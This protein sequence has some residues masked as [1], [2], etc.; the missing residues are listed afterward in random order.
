MIFSFVCK[1]VYYLLK[2]NSLVIDFKKR[3]SRGRHSAHAF[4]CFLGLRGF[5]RH[6]QGPLL[7]AGALSG[8]GGAPRGAQ[9][10]V[11]GWRLRV[12]GAAHKLQ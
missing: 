1:N 11:P 7:P 4:S 3:A 6:S 2:V 5:P 8:E 10:P 12:Q 9:L